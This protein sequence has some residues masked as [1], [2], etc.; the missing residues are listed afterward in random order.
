[1]K[2][3]DRKVLQKEEKLAATLELDK[4]NTHLRNCR[5]EVDNLRR[6]SVDANNHDI[7]GLKRQ[8]GLAEQVSRDTAIALENQSIIL[9]K[10][11]LALD[12]KTELINAKNEIIENLKIVL[13][14]NLRKK[15]LGLTNIL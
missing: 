12:S 10:T 7:K 5:E 3:N 9:K 8:L 4:S 6:N 13:L 15:F 11:E 14:I 1:M 2:E